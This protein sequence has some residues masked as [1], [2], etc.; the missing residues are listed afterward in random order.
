VIQ[1]IQVWAYLMLFI[2]SRFP[3]RDERGRVNARDAHGLRERS[4]CAWEIAHT[5]C[6]P[7]ECLRLA[8]IPALESGYEYRAVG[9]Q[10]ERGPWQIHPPAR[11]YGAREALARLRAQGIFGY[12]GCGSART[13]L[14]E[15]MAEHRT[16]PARDWLAEHP[17]PV[18]ELASGASQS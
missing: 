8:N 11:S 13:K 15:D 18:A 5:D 6:G 7:E 1:A 4:R 3:P 14:C 17:W 2:L 9:K 12:I 16:G 10:G